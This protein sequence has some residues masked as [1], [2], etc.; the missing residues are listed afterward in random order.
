MPTDHRLPARRLAIA[1]SILATT[2]GCQFTAAEDEY[3]PA[4]RQPFTIDNIL[5]RDPVNLDGSYERGMQWCD[6]G[7]HYLQRRDG[8]LMKVDILTENAEQEPREQKLI[9]MLRDHSAFGRRHAT[10]HATHPAGR[11]TDR[12]GALL[13]RHNVLYFADL[14]TGHIRTLTHE[15][16]NYRFPQL[17]PSGDTVS[18]VRDNDLYTFD[19]ASGRE[20]RLTCDGS[21][22]I[23]NGVLDWVYQEEIYGRGRW[24]ASWWSGDG[25]H[26]AFLRLDD[27]NVPE[28]AI[29]DFMP[30]QPEVEVLRYPKAGD[31]NPVVTLGIARAE[32]GRVAWADLTRYAGADILITH[33]SWSPTGSLLFAVQDR[34]QRWLELNEADPQTGTTRVLLREASPAWVMEG[35]AP[36]W[37]PDGSFLWRSDRDGYCHIYHYAADGQLIR[38]LTRGEWS[39]R[40]ILGVDTESQ[41]V[42][43]S[44]A[45]RTPVETQAYRVPLA[46]GEITQLTQD[47]YSHNVNLDPTCQRFFDTYSNCTTP[48]QVELRSTAGELIRTVS[49]NNVAALDEYIWSPPE[50][51]HFENRAGLP[52]NAII[53]RPPDFDPQRKYPVVCSVYGGPGAPI[54]RNTWGGSW[55]VYQQYLA[56]Q[57]CIVWR[58]D[59]H[60]ST[61]GVPIAH[62]QAYRQLGQAELADIEDSLNWLIEQGYADPDRILIEGGSYGG[63]VTSYALTH[64]PMFAAGI[65]QFPVTDWRNYDSVYTERYMQTPAH[66]EEGYKLASVVKAAADLRGRL[67]LTHGM[68]DDNALFQNSV[69]LIEALQRH[70]KQFELMI[71]PRDRHGIGHGRV[72]HLE[73]RLR[74]IREQL[75][76]DETASTE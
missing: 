11:T 45:A 72:H 3:Q 66:N 68:R 64:S 23:L 50:I 62:W 29:L 24:N 56:Q 38:R 1:L 12:D 17:S 10:R 8:T 69:Q 41:F 15:K 35:G 28:Y 44:G 54:V 27:T 31:P 58:P 63:F 36:Y 16:F 18:F 33:V 21:E 43:F 65:C 75:A 48:T 71:Y 40:G 4:E 76:L 51:V 14:N 2:L 52:M 59:P 19:T 61:V 13:D 9:E 34:E 7:L 74:F 6:D 53:V 57:G 49:E 55:Q 32:N 39:V 25:A 20:R 42:Y 37:L 47:G 70:E 5:G 67:L 73:M 46:G 30:H 22:T 26:L 60:S